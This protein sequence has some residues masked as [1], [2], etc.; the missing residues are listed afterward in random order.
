VAIHEF[1]HQLD[2]EKGYANGAPLLPSRERYLRWSRVLGYEFARLR[3]AEA[4]GLP[5]LFSY[6]GA[7]DPAEFFAVASEV[8]YEQPQ[9]LAL[10]H[11]QLYEELRGFYRVDPRA[12][13]RRAMR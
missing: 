9:R 5:S 12:F 2:Q 8:F 13:Q 3:E 7:T 1:A 4:L 11:S 6:Y 10:E